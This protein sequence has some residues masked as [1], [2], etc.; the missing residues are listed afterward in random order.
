[1]FSAPAKIFFCFLTTALHKQR[2]TR[3]TRTLRNTHTITGKVEKEACVW[4]AGGGGGEKKQQAC[5]YFTL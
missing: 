4:G 1:M 3:T 5:A 2:D